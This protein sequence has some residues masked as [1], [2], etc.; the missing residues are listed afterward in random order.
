MY[1]IISLAVIAIAIVGMI[2]AVI[3]RYQKCPSDKVLVIYGKVGGEASKCLHGGAAFI[4]PII[5]A[6]QFLSLRPIQLEVKLRGALSKQ[7]IRI[8]VPSNFTVAIST[9]PS[10]MKNAAQRLLGHTHD[11][12][13][14]IA[15]D[16]IF[17]QLRIVIATMTIEEINNDRE[18]F[19]ESITKEVATELQK[20]GLELINVNIQDITD[21][22]GFID[23]LGKKASSE[24]IQ[25]AR[26]EVAEKEKE[27]AIGTALAEKE[28]RIAVAKAEADAISG[29]NQSK[30]KQ[31]IADGELFEAQA[32]AK[33]KASQ[34]KQI[35]DAEAEQKAFE[36]QTK[37]EQARQET[38]MAQA[39][40]TIIVQ[41]EI[42][43]RKKI[44]EAQAVSE[45][46]LTRATGEA[47]ATLVKYNAEAKGLEEVLSKRAEGFKNLI[48][49]SGSSEKAVQLMLAD[50][51]VDLTKI[52]TEAI[53]NI[54][55]DKITV[56][57]QGKGENGKNSTANFLSG[58]VN[59]LPHQQ[60]LFKNIG[61]ELPEMIKPKEIEKNTEDLPEPT[62]A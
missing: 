59:S 49:S 58:I 51:V 1:F 56:W 45:E 20:I 61:L 33:A 47:D 7:K 15:E 29:E 18:K 42:A 10:I 8:D 44:L 14:M 40:A 9:E 62:H 55:I 2:I 25:N 12:I 46:T 32:K 3:S 4:W 36:A 57:E 17:G 11:Q 35:A 21:E 23:A 38:E 52:Q 60:E 27:G 31:A 43:K 41:A 54:K 28:Q 48:T 39:N 22:S 5:Q 53:K 37:K 30:A 19:M 6:F 26:I 13:K 16:I 24:A 34:A 50:K